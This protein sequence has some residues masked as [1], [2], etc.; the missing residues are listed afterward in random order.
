MLEPDINLLPDDLKSSKRFKASPAPGALQDNKP[1]EAEKPQA[2]KKPLAPAPAP[3]KNKKPSSYKG[4]GSFFKERLKIIGRSKKGDHP[5]APGEERDAFE[6]ELLTEDVLGPRSVRRE[7]LA[8]FGIV[9]AFIVVFAFV[10]MY[11]EWRIQKIQTA[12][13]IVMEESAQ[14]DIKIARA[15]K[16]LER[17]RQTAG[18]V[19]TIDAALAHR[20]DWNEIFARI[21]S[22]TLKTVYYTNFASEEDGLLKLTARAKTPEDAQLQIL[23]F[24]NAE[25]FIESVVV[26]E[27]SVEEETITVLGDE[28]GEQ[29]VSSFVEFP[30][31]I[32]LSQDWFY[33]KTKNN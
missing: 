18:I 30:M 23:V 10:F 11:Y 16:E 19:A 17:G 1:K 4:L 33:G 22:L 13:L 5:T 28:N 26:E 3:D 24:R 21:E 20:V 29:V 15:K 9:F 6:V 32:A 31:T 12:T 7:L 14:L 8:L 25:D 2:V 27:F